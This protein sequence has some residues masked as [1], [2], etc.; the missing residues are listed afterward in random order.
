MGFLY[1]SG[2]SKSEYLASSNPYGGGDSDCYV[3][4]INPASLNLVF[5]TYIGGNASE[6]FCRVTTSSIPGVIYLQGATRS[7]NIPVTPTAYQNVS[8]PGNAG[9]NFFAV[10]NTNNL[11]TSL[12]S[13]QNYVPSNETCLCYVTFDNDCSCTYPRPF[14]GD[15]AYCNNGT[16]TLYSKVSVDDNSTVF[17]DGGNIVVIN[18][19]LIDNGGTIEIGHGSGIQVWENFSTNSNSSISFTGVGKNGTS[20]G[21]N[22]NGCAD[23]QG[24]MNLT[25]DAGYIPRDGDQ[26][27]FINASC[28]GGSNYTV[29]I[30][31]PPVTQ[32]SC[33]VTTWTAIAT[34]T[35]TE[36]GVSYGAL[37]QSQTTTIS[38]CNMPGTSVTWIY[39]VIA[40]GVAV[41]VVIAVIIAIVIRQ[42]YRRRGLR[43]KT[44]EL[45]IRNGHD[46]FIEIAPTDGSKDSNDSKESW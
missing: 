34:S 46:S 27:T 10:I 17:V 31:N 7:I 39:Y 33:N 38:G 6:T 41:L 26:F 45:A 37:L 35:Q 12:N 19:S 21:I 28:D 18:G 16:W 42:K 14:P 2:F 30:G 20:G 5:G 44:V 43:Q 9:T 13:T 29:T 32:N 4:K 23:I 1:F 25:F 40:F 11:T 24:N 15:H 3:A 8:I 36:Q 22:V